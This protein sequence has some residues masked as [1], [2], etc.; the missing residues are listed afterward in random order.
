MRRV[1]LLDARTAWL[2]VGEDSLGAFDNIDGER[3]KEGMCSVW[4][5]QC[6]YPQ[7]GRARRSPLSSLCSTNVLEWLEPPLSAAEL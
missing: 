3:E 4:W 2:E 5:V 1:I 7:C 6:Y